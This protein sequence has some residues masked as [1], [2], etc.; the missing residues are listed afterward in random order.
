MNNRKA[1]VQDFHSWNDVLNFAISMEQISHQFYSDLQP[2]MNNPSVRD[3]L[4]RLA[5]EERLHIEQLENLKSHPWAGAFE[6][7]SAAEIS[8]YIVASVPPSDMSYK[9]TIKLAMD[10]EHGSRLFYSLL[11]VSLEE[12]ELKDIF[13]VLSQQEQQ[14]WLRF[15]KE[16]EA[17]SL[18]EN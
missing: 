9:E 17:I 10:K 4:K 3:L 2:R 15:K 7:I 6:T 5:A 11:A 18:A 14:H 12:Q 8:G 1:D 13:T 16:Y